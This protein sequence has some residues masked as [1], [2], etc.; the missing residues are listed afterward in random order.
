MYEDY[1][2]LDTKPFE[3]VPTKHGFYPGQSHEGTMLK[4]RYVIEQQR[5]CVALAG[6]SGVGKTLLIS[7]LL[8]EMSEPDAKLRLGPVV[9]LVYPQM[10]DRDLLSYMASSLGAADP[11]FAGGVPTIESSVRA[12]DGRLR[13]VADQGQHAVIVVDEAHLLEDCGSLEVFRLLLNLG[14]QHK[15]AMTFLLVGQMSLISAIG[16]AAGLEERISVKAL[17]RRF[18]ADETTAYIQH[19]LAA[20]GAK[21]DIF[22]PSACQTIHELTDGTARKIDRLGDLALLVGFANQVTGIDAE[23]I[24]SVSQELVALTPE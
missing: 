19:R 2:Q 9:H 7:H 6:P 10:S 14:H 3:P 8:E 4:L 18:T 5:G 24:E 12:I 1:W 13:E 22:S 20:A 15:P 17:L 21:Q 11:G 23:H 16:R